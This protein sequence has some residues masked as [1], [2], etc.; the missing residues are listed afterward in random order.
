M[1]QSAFLERVWRVIP[2]A[3]VHGVP[4]LRQMR[5]GVVQQ[6]LELASN[7]YHSG[8]D[9]EAIEHLQQALA[10][11]PDNLEALVTLGSVYFVSKRFED[12]VKVFSRV[13]DIDY[14]NTKA[15][16]GRAYALDLLGRTDE[17]IYDY[18]RFLSLKTDDAEVHA[19]FV[20]ALLNC[21]KTDE[22]ITAGERAKTQFPEDVMLRE[23]LA[24]AYYNAGR[25]VDAEDQIETACTLDP[26]RADSFQRAGL[27]YS[28][29]GKTEKAAEALRRAVSLNPNNPENYLY[30]ADVLDTLGRYDECRE[31]ATKAKSLFETENDTIGLSGAF[32]ALGW[33]NYRLGRWTESAEASAKAVELNPK[34]PVPRFN[35]GLALLR[36]GEVQRA[37]EAYRAALALDDQTALMRDGIGDLTDAMT[38][39]PNLPGAAEILSE[40]QAHAKPTRTATRR[41]RRGTSAANPA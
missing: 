16:K 12:T 34:A 35:L 15:L 24:Q 30:L 41:T 40:L 9:A 31:A 19:N 4:G 2:N 22:A 5:H 6:H 3:I 36:Q 17:A 27:I 20:A 33:A 32:W 37:T 26:D 25:F 29:T 7:A 13:L 8:A 21:G 11:E 39:S 1:L 28:G 23:L 10:L 18:L 14:F 38:E